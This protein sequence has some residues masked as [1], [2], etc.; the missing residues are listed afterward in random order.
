MNEKE[1]I[2]VKNNEVREKAY[3][4]PFPGL[5]AFNFEESHLFFG[6]E[7]HCDEIL[8]KLH[9]HHFVSIIGTSGSG[10]S[11]LMYCGLL[12]ILYGGFM[13]KAGSRWK[14]FTSRPGLEPIN[15]LARELFIN[16]R[17]KESL[18]DQEIIEGTAAINS[19]L[20]SNHHGLLD[21][22]KHR[23]K[24]ENQNILIL[25]D[26]FEELFR[27]YAEDVKHAPEILTFV[28][29]LTEAVNHREVPVYVVITMRS[30]FVGESAKFPQLTK[31][32]NNSHYLIP[33]LNR[34]EQQIAIEGPVA[35][36]GSKISKRLVQQLLNDLSNNANQLPVM[37][38][39]LM[40]TWNFWQEN[41]DVDEPL[42]LR[43]YRAIGSI[44]EALSMH[45]DE[46]YNELSAREKEICET[47]F[48]SLT[49]KGKDS[50][51]IRRQAKLSQIAQ[52]ARVSEE[53]VIP[54]I[55]LFR[56]PSRSLL[57]PPLH[58]PLHSDTII[59]ISHESLMR[60]WEKLKKWVDEESKSA[61]MYLRLSEA[62]ERYN[63]GS[64]GL[65]RPPD[66]Q[67]AL[68]W[69]K[70]QNPSFAWAQR[71]N[72]RFESAINFLEFSEDNYKKE[73]E[74]EVK[75]Q[76]RRIAR[77]KMVSLFL[78]M[79]TV[80]SILF[81]IFAIMKKGEADDAAIEARLNERKA[82]EANE[83]LS[84]RMEELRITTLEK[85]QALVEAQ[86]QRDSA[87]DARLKA[88]SA[89]LAAMTSAERERIQKQR[90]EQALVAEKNAKEQLQKSNKELAEEQEKVILSEQEAI[91][92]KLRFLAQTMALKSLRVLDE[93]VQGALAMQAYLYNVEYKGYTYE[94]NIYDGLY[95]ALK[96]LKQGK[97]IYQL[98]AHSDAIRSI[99][100]VGNDV[101][102][103]GSDGSIKK[104]NLN[105]YLESQQVIYDNNYI[106]RSL[107]LSKNNRWLINAGHAN[108]V[109]L[110]D[111]RNQNR[112]PVKIEGHNNI[113]YDLEFLPNNQ[114]FITTSADS[115]FRLNDFKSSR[116][117]K[118]NENQVHSIAISNDG[119]HI[120]G[121]SVNGK[122][123]L[124]ES[125]NM[126]K[127]TV[128]MNV[129][130][131]IHVVQFSPS[132]KYLAIGDD[133]G[134]M[135]ILQFDKDR[136]EVVSSTAFAGHESRINDIQ[137]SK[138]EFFIASAGFDGRILLYAM[139]NL[140]ELPITMRD[141]ESYVWS[142]TFNDSGKYLIA[143]GKDGVVKI[144]PTN[145]SVLA[146]QICGLLK[147]NLTKEEWR[148]YVADD[149]EYQ[150]T[151]PDLIAVK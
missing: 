129:K 83:E 82:I 31:L 54:I 7:G 107:K 11:S 137:F 45:A 69:R 116:L 19:I 103:T 149:L 119:K 87:N 108:Y 118:K 111:L 72:P 144:W 115:T 55:N 75:R 125:T 30:D 2:L 136:K 73:Q 100:V 120:A 61:Q 3:T 58:A 16:G 127:E 102:S 95:Y 126:D 151:C 132:G 85:D 64:T 105:N 141:H 59:E 98:K 20:R 37:Q 14:V 51:G 70:E 88:D 46:T 139:D 36:G 22:I 5:R 89:R 18:P 68:N 99:V 28:N 145:P 71:Y 39:A 35:V 40:R 146:E 60:I 66:L 10:K 1:T 106:N 135:T 6:R 4:N 90:A 140:D 114:Y 26:Q 143:G 38:H 34:N 49:E 25:I 101:F 122:V 150:Y 93:D 23:V 138:D 41:H 80:I 21:V 96:M 9:K 8:L 121:G 33:Q 94:N 130:Y 50:S 92:Q 113:I 147:R 67:L 104:F 133:K 76:K 124:W 97:D 17:D 74:R 53:E 123:H 128:L 81:F 52:I 57:L 42:D 117:L 24:S 77:I 13:T 134:T 148:R 47:I 44:H 79:A 32:I 62:A 63:S 15:N 48:K 27:L 91:Q 109:Q 65:W 78:G 56:H 12:P 112:V 29:L 110:F 43:H 131:P 84:Q 86:V 142:I